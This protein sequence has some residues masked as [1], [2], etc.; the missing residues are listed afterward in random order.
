M[1]GSIMAELRKM[2][3]SALIGI[4]TSYPYGTWVSQALCSTTSDSGNIRWNES[5]VYVRDC[6]RGLLNGCG[7]LIRR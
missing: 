6:P 7:L 5:P 4:A 1:V 3:A 2:N